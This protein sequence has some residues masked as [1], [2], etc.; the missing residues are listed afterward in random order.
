[1]IRVSVETN[2]EDISEWRMRQIKD[3]FRDLCY[4]WNL[5]RVDITNYDAK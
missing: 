4:I 1:M 2:R 5:K 3:E